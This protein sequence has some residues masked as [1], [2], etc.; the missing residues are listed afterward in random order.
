MI[1][2][3]L[4][5]GVNVDHVATIRNAR[6]GRHP[7][8]VRA[9]KL[10]IAAGADGITAHLREDR[11]HIRDDDIA[12][13]KAE[14]DKPLNFEMA[15]TE[16]NDRDRAQDPAARGVPGA[17][18]AHRTHHRRRARCRQAARA[19]RSRWCTRSSTP[20]SASRCSS[21]AAAAQIEAA[22][23]LGAPVVELHT[24]SWCDALIEN[25]AAEAAAEWQL[26]RAGA[27]LAKSLGLEVHAGH[28]L[29]Y[30]SAETIAALPQIV[31]LNIGHFLVGE[32][33]FE[34][35]AETVKFMRAA[36]DRGRRKFALMIIGLGSDM[37]DVRRIAR[38][39]ERYGERFL[40]RIFTAA[41]RAKAESRANMVETYAKRFAAK[42]ACSKALGTGFRSGVFWRDMGVVNLPSG[43]AH[44]EA[45]RRRAQTAAGDHAGRLRGADRRFAHRR[46]S[47]RAGHRDHFG[48]AEDAGVK[49]RN[50]IRPNAYTAARAFL[51]APRDG[52]R[53]KVA[54]ALRLWWRD[55]RP[56]SVTSGTKRKEGGIAETIRVVVHALII[57][58][59]IRTFLFQP[60]N[61]P[62]GSMKATLLVGDYL[63]VSKYT[64]GY[65]HFSLP[66][67]PPLF[68]GRIPSDWLPQRGDV[69]VFRLPKDT[70]TDYIK[71][72]IG[73]PGDKIQVIDGGLYIN[74]VGGQARAGAAVRRDR[75]RQRPPRR[76][77]AG[78]IRSTTA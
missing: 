58:L 45:D 14:I 26:I 44:H 57:A 12:R 11:R 78:R 29:D 32:S 56:M 5:L 59:V 69:V 33:V 41:E 30:A 35:L 9:A 3:P 50:T 25:R 21:R 66:F 72:V 1:A 18:K 46:R 52:S 63:F 24:G 23:E 54:G 60:F 16:R 68:S 10:A 40:G 17:G 42:E 19:A 38:S 77:N 62:S 4:R 76:S 74:G 75:R 6:G 13:L 39:I 7:D 71:R 15:A 36:M 8:P 70:S 28:G 48:A 27:L 51:I 22:A 67:S 43:P 2:L 47:G 37:V 64:Y 73:L 53:Y 31:E 49:P 34:G 55:M 61:I 65:S 20:A